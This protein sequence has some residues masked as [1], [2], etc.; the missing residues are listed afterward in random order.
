MVRER[1]CPVCDA[2]LIFA[3]D[4]GKGDIVVCSYCGAPFTVRTVASDEEDWEL[5]DDF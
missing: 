4:E 3:G 2:D 1:A 5:D